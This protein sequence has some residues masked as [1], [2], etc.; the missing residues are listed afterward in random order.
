MDR[1]EVI[2]LVNQTFTYDTIGNPTATETQTQVYCNVESCGQ[3][4]FYRAGQIGLKPE[5]KVTMFKYDYNDQ[6][7]AI[8]KNKRYNIYRTYFKTNEEIE[9]YLN[10]VKGL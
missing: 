6:V 7:I 2:S 4:E 3:N 8:Y 10:E 9:L 1:S 5:Y